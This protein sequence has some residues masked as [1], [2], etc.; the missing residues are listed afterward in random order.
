MS[1]ESFEPQRS[2]VTIRLI[3]KKDKNRQT[4]HIAR[5][6]APMLLDLSQCTIFVFTGDMPQIT[7]R[8]TKTE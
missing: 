3:P 1:S 8:K 5:C 7:I 4:Y 6:D 2:E